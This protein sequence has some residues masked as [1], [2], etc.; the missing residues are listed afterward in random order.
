MALDLKPA[1]R[2][3][4][5]RLYLDPNNPRLGGSRQPGYEDTARLFDE[6]TQRRLESRMRKSYK[7]LKDLMASIVNVG[8]MPVDAILVW[9]VPQAPGHFVVVEGNARTTALRAIREDHAREQGRLQ[10]ARADRLLDPEMQKELAGRVARLA[11]V[12]E[13][14]AEL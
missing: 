12:I 13:Q 10:K 2:V 14:T 8:W 9:E 5:D 11:A 3:P 1:L 6:R 4:F 7:A